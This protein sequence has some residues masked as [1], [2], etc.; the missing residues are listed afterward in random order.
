MSSEGT[1]GLRLEQVDADGAIRETAEEAMATLEENGDT[2]L[3]FFKKAGIAGGAVVS[4]GALLGVLAPGTALAQPMSKGGRPPK[5]FGQ[6]D[7][8]ILNY[9]LTLE[10][11]EAAFY[12]EATAN[13]FATGQT[14]I[15]LKRTTEDENTHVKFLKGALGGKAVKSPKFDFGTTTT[16]AAEFLPTAYALENTGVQ[17]YMGQAFNIEKRA[18]LKAALTIVTVEARHAS[19]F[20][21]LALNSAHAISPSGAFDRGRKAKR[22][23]SAVGETHF[24]Q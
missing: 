24:I 11:L 9:A 12:N 6:G 22:I 17:A 15:A 4:G 5:S 13:G 20:G 2:R 18:Y 21:L 23:L 14:Q 8:G 16:N 19:V 1:N 10:Y 7:I 3:D